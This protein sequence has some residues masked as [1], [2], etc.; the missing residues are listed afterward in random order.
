[1]RRGRWPNWPNRWSVKAR[2]RALLAALV[3]APGPAAAAVTCS[4]SG[5]T[6]A[7]GAYDVLATAP[8]DAQASLVVTCTRDGGRATT[9]IEVG[10]GPSLTSGSVQ[11]RRLAGPGGALLDYNVYQDAPR[12]TVWGNTSGVDTRSQNLTL[13][14]RATGSV[15]FT[16][17]GRLFQGQD[18]SAG[19]YSDSLL[20]TVSY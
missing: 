20:I 12:L 10:L 15:T 1:M 8:A 11:N 4:G 3:L 7:F 17:F 6:L 2:A 5:V 9:T 14:N 16:L 13:A 18:V 19:S